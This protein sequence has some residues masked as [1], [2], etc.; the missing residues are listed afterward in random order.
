VKNTVFVVDDDPAV[1]DSL[2][3]L[4]EAA[5]YVVETFASAE[6]FLA[7]F[8]PARPG[9]IVLDERMPGMSGHALQTELVR[10]R[11][12]CPVI[13]ITAYAEVPMTVAAMQLGAVTL[14]EKPF[15]E[16]ALLDAIAQALERDTAKRTRYENRRD[17]ESRLE[18]L[19]P[20]QREVMELLIRG[21]SNKLIATE[22]GISD[23]T[24]ELHRARVLRNMEAGSVAELAFAVGRA[25][26]EG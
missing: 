21:L 4:I 8:D 25:R 1:R 15:R 14:L 19:T 16:Q 24:V 2:R 12:I 20:R 5:G 17:L 23:R 26:G 10:R 13:L 9:C 6:E 18:G 3:I 11:A 7:R 22:L